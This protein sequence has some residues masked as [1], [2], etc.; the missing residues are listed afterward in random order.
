MHRP[1][2]LLA[3]TINTLTYLTSCACHSS[4]TAVLSLSAPAAVAAAAVAAASE[5][6]NKILKNTEFQ[7]HCLNLQSP[8]FAMLNITPWS[9][10]LPIWPAVVY[11]EPHAPVAAA[12]EVAMT[13]LKLHGH[14]VI[15]STFNSLSAHEFCLHDHSTCGM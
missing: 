15:D 6:V 3:A 4:A 2:P 5:L 10:V 14:G 12:T 13:A 11:I 7:C 8:S 1:Q 9:L